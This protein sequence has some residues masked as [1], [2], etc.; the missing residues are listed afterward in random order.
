MSSR[1]PHWH[2]GMFLRPQHLQEAQR[3]QEHLCRIGD[4]W[5]LNY[6][7]G[8]RQITID[9]EPLANYRLLIPALQARMR[10]GTLVNVPDEVQLPERD[11]R[12]VLQDQ[13]SVTVYLAVPLLRPGR[14]NISSNGSLGEPSRYSLDTQEVEDENTG[15][16]PQK[17]Q[18]RLLNV[19][20]LLS[21]EEQAGYE[22][23]PIA[24]I[25][26]SSGV[27]GTPQLDKYYIPPLLGCDAW[28]GLQR[29][30]IQ[31]LYD[32]LGQYRREW[33]DQVRTS[34][35]PIESSSGT[36]A[37]TV[38]TLRILNEASASLGVLTFV[39]GR[40]PLEMYLVLCQ[41]V[42]QLAIFGE[43]RETPDLPR[44]DHDD[45]G[46][47][48]YKVRDLILDLFRRNKPSYERRP[49][50]GMPDWGLKV[51]IEPSWLDESNEMYV[52]VQ[53]SL[54]P[55]ECIDL[56]TNPG[57]L[58][59][60]I[61]SHRRVEEIH[62]GGF[63]GLRFG[64]TPAPPRVLPK[65]VIYFQVR[66]DSQPGEWGHVRTDRTLALWLNKNSVGTPIAPGQREL[67]IKP[68]GTSAQSQTPA[69]F[70][71]TLFVVPRSET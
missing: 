19:R 47:C 57:R 50:E 55:T 26:K 52:G 9:P 62:R 25:E 30:I 33:A 14:P 65:D 13:A 43:T 18:V 51:E 10:D 69:T 24:R 31:N 20:L 46:P 40:H 58:N 22:T 4:K 34:G 48:F 59:V 68:G 35:I 56:I 44:Y 15:R 49:F 67:K 23:L 21:S 28:E 27:A 71:F 11:L 42:G 54:P 36:D 16:N 2:E 32:R 6:N 5:D 7:W 60:K 37:L 17:L 41:L 45:L 63:P 61:G 1:P 12:P 66:R 38:S 3:Y 53:T 29:G 8:L 39:K 64:H 70:Q